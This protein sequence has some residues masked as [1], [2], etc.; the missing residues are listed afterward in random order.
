[1]PNGTENHVPE[2]P[3]GTVNVGAESTVVSPVKNV[4][5][6]ENP[7]FVVYPI[8]MVRFVKTEGVAIPELPYI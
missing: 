2:V 5:E 3:A 1:M 6:G 7:V 4:V 8:L